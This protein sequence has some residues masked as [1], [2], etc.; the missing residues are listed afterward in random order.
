M[1][2]LWEGFGGPGKTWEKVEAGKTQERLNS[3]FPQAKADF[4]CELGINTTAEFRRRQEVE[5]DK[6]GPRFKGTA[7][8]GLTSISQEWV[9]SSERG[10]SLSPPALTPVSSGRRS[11]NFVR[12]PALKSVPSPAESSTSSEPEIPW[13][14]MPGSGQVLF[15]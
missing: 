2:S 7:H 6:L 8:I 9:R 13:F 14:Q 4:G 5:E 12:R 1:T 10:G 3:F 11:S 15:F